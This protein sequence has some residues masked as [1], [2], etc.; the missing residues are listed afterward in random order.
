MPQ[1]AKP[2]ARD[3]ILNCHY[4][5]L[6]LDALRAAVNNSAIAIP[7]GVC[8]VYSEKISKTT[9]TLNS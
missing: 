9:L 7:N 4:I 8:H 1:Q 3:K 5:E 6:R 2:Y